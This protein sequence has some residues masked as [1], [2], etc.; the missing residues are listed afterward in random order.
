[1]SAPPILIVHDRAQALAAFAA[2]RALRRAVRIETPAELAHVLG[3]AWMR[4]FLDGCAAE[5]LTPPGTVAFHCGDAPGLAL[6]ALKLNL[7]ALRFAPAADA[8]PRVAEAIAAIAAAQETDLALG[9]PTGAAWRF[10]P[11]GGAPDPHA[12]ELAAKRWL[13]G[14]PS[15]GDLL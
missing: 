13:G 10:P 7:P 9:P 8:P 6:A 15:G 5:R 4:A 14:L 1:V 11:P 2:A 3:P 12:L